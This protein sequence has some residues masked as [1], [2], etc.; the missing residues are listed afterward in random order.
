MIGEKCLKIPFHSNV[1]V[2][3]SRPG[4]H[5][6]F[7]RLKEASLFGTGPRKNHIIIILMFI[8]EKEKNH[9]KMSIPSSIVQIVTLQESQSLQ[10]LSL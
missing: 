5:I 6:I 2:L 3:Q 8:N 7:Y 4:L 10:N 1:A 9:L